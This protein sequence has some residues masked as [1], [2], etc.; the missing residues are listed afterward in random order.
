[1]V[2]EK[3]KSNDEDHFTYDD[4]VR[5]AGDKKSLQTENIEKQKLQS[6]TARFVTPEPMTLTLFDDD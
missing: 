5:S 2:F 4:F 6:K 3:I 1:M